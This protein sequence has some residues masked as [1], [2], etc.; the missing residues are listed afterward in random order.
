MFKFAIEKPVILTVIILIVCLFGILAVFRVPIQMIPDLDVRA[1]SVSTSWPGATPQDIEKEIVIEQEEFLRRIPSLDRMISRASTGRAEIELEFPSGTDINEVLIRV[2]NAL[3]QVQGYP[4]NVDE[5]R[6][7]TSSISNN[8]FIF[9]RT[10]PL[11]GNPLNINMIQMRDFLEDH[12]RTRLERVTGVSE[13]PLWGGAERQIRIYV[14]PIKLAERQL[15]L[16]D[17]RNAV[18]SRNRDVSGG[19]LDSGKRRY[20][21]RT[22]GRFESVEEIE[23]LVIGRQGDAF[24]RLSDVGYAELSNFEVRSYSYVNG[25]PTISVGIKRQIG[26]NVVEVMDAVVAEVAELNKSL[27]PAHGIQMNLNS[28]DV[29]YVRA[30]VKNVRRKPYYWW[31][32]GN[33]GAVFIFTFIFGNHGRC[34]RYSDMYD[35]CLSRF[36]YNRSN[37]QRHFISG[38]G[39]RHWN[40][41]R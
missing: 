38:S 9:F 17:V 33:T 23:K 26:A 16:I 20:L 1:I 11:E 32:A 7:V 40:D 25:Q 19:D 24:I 14:D 13:V 21:L 27:L 15:R 10:T 2:N 36:A 3:S 30:S 6:I 8:A 34:Y 31:F 18:R 4:E 29:R 5:P 39:L 12:V 28:D 22:V 37:N 41:P 35:R